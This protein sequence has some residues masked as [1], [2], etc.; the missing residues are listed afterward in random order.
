MGNIKSN[1]CHNKLDCTTFNKHDI[2]TIKIKPDLYP[3]ETTWKI[4]SISSLT[5][6]P[7]I[8]IMHG[9]IMHGGPYPEQKVYK[10]SQCFSKGMYKFT[11]YDEYGDGICCSDG[12]NGH[13]KIIIGGI[14]EKT[15]GQFYNDDSF[16][17]NV[18]DSKATITASPTTFSPTKKPTNEKIKKKIKKKRRMYLLIYLLIY[19]LLQHLHL[20]NLLLLVIP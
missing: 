1:T 18:T 5:T 15:G 11:I 17:F 9:I 20:R 6:N 2:V 3:K 12:R 10:K 4:S 19:L 13:Y 14:E 16:I 7:M 8:I